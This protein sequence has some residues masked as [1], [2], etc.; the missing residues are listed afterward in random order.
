[1]ADMLTPPFIRRAPITLRCARAMSPCLNVSGFIGLSAKL[2]HS[3]ISIG[4]KGDIWFGAMD[5]GIDARKKSNLTFN[6][7]YASI[8]IGL[9]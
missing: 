7:P 8:S 9:P 2:P 1:M 3:K 4:Y 5:S 6:G